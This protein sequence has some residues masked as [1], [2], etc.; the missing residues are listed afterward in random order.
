MCDCSSFVS[1]IKKGGAALEAA[2]R[3]IVSGSDACEFKKI[4]AYVFNRYSY[5]CGSSYTWE[6]LF[7]EA[8]MRFIKAVD[9]G[10]EP[11]GKDCRPFFFQI[12]KYTCWEWCRKDGGKLVT[13]ENTKND[14]DY[15]RGWMEDLVILMDLIPDLKTIALDCL[16][17]ASRKCQIL[18]QARYFD[19]PPIKDPQQ[20]AGLLQKAGYKVNPKNMPQ[21]ISNCLGPYRQ[22]LQSKL[23]I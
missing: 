12:C 6:D 15:T 3:Q 5:C 9:R 10:N 22:C 17:S 7:Y 11:N 13:G 8:L 14:G 16:K 2:L 18:L 19:T 4:S 23:I 20:L 21:E 1:A